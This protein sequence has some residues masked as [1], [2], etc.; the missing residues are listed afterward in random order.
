MAVF[1]LEDRRAASRSS[2]FPETFAQRGRLIE[3]GTLVLVR[4]KL[5]RDDERRGS[6]RPRSCRSTACASGSRARWRSTV[7][8]AA[9]PRDV[10]GARRD[11]LAP[12]RRP[13]R[14][15]RDRGAGGSREP[16]RVRA[17]VA[18]RFASGR[19]RAL[20]AEVEQIVGAGLGVA[21][22]SA[23]DAMPET[24]EFE[25]PIAVLLKEI[26]ALTLLPRHRRAR[27]RDRRAAPARRVDPRASSTR[28]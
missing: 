23:S 17:D 9:R 8:A 13:P 12:P 24:L 26:E 1:T 19:R 16:L 4:G 10:R 22:M 7:D 11:V 21:A 18:R 27:A 14:V 6:W 20:I 2:C 5:E 28:R 25:E 3:T 15:V